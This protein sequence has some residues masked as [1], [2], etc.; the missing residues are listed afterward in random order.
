MSLR[1]LHLLA[2]PVFS[3]PASLVLELARAQ[4]ALG[5]TVSVAIDRKRAGL[6]SEEPGAPRF[7]QAG[8]LDE[9]G[10]ELSVKST[11]AAAIAD[12][13]RLRERALDV[14]HAHFSHDHLVARFANRKGRALVRSLHAPRSIRWSMP[15]AHAFTVPYAA[16]LSALPHARALVL[17]ALVG[18][19]FAPPSDLLALRA[20]LQLDGEPLYGMVS[21]FQA[22]RRHALG[23]EAFAA[24]RAHQPRAR[25]V[26]LGDGELEAPLRVKAERLGITAQVTFAGYRS[27]A[28]FV[29]WLRA[30]D[31]VWLL[32]LGNDFAARAAVEARACGVRVLAVEEGALGLWADQVILPEPS[33][34]VAA[35]LE[36]T[37]RALELPVAAE[38]A[39]RV[40]ALYAGVL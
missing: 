11:P 28:E 12:A 24:L 38:V 35:A 17:P 18:S 21:T 20:R 16:L 8:L 26:L 14:V 6:G 10:L 36:P 29:D 15:R 37:R 7:A 3:G 39:Q 34:L 25:L 30:L 4:A 22:S 40:L 19:E 32:G 5:H 13:R 27:G 33:A 2:S 9:G 1:I 23:L 31:A